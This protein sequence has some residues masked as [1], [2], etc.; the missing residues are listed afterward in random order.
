MTLKN[1]LRLEGMTAEEKK[2]FELGFFF[3]KDG[4]LKGLNANRF[5]KYIE[6]RYYF[7][8]RN[9]NEFEYYADGVW[10]QYPKMAFSKLLYE[11]LESVKPN[12]WKLTYEKET[13]EVLKRIL[14]TDVEFNSN[15]NL[16]N[17]QNGMYNIETHELLDHDLEY[18]S[19]V[20]LPYAYDE[21]AECPRF[22]QFLDEVFE[23]DEERIFKALEWMGYCMT[24]ETQA[25]KSLILVGGGSNGKGV[26][27]EIMTMLVGKENI[28]N[29]PLLDLGTDFNRVHLYNKTVNMAG[30][31]EVGKSGFNSQYFKTIIGEDTIT[32]AHKGIDG[33]SF[34]PFCKLV[35]T[36][37]NLPFTMDKSD[38]YFRRLDFLPFTR[39]FTDHEKDPYLREKLKEEIPGIFN[40][41]M[42]GLARLQANG[43]RF[44]TSQVSEN[45]LQE[46]KEELSPMMQ[47]F[48]ER[49]TESEEEDR[50]E[51]Q[52][53]Y[54][55]YIAWLKDNGYK[56]HTHLT[57]K[58]F[59]R[60]FLEE[61]KKRQMKITSRHSG[62]SRYKTG[63]KLEKEYF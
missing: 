30:E 11:E 13:L 10:K 37:N 17:L 41:A 35:L 28:S 19:S 33:F 26:F 51:N 8:Y 63:F 40:L 43:Y 44:T 6:S 53:V 1:E 45:L 9:G 49:I 47:F 55:A 20:Q 57:T 42:K 15:R 3:S 54:N 25:Q 24:V 34:K 36:F 56:S 46:Y 38:G 7:I 29:V 39:H 4:N 52:T 61:A 5:A 50:V 58:S 16:I 22:E 27:S 23:S 21:N 14:Y 62:S 59:W 2:L 18:Y 60:E 12:L 31:N 32:A 48:N